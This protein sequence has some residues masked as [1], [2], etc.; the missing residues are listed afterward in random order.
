MVRA[1]KKPGS[2]SEEMFWCDYC[3]SWYCT[4]EWT[5]RTLYTLEGSH[6]EVNSE[7]MYEDYVSWDVYFCDECDNVLA[8]DER[9]GT[10]HRDRWVC[11]ECKEEHS[12]QELAQE[13]CN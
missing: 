12:D 7:Y 5:E 4:D 6:W 1:Y 3:E 2:E 10:E 11:G 13:C 9:P 8:V